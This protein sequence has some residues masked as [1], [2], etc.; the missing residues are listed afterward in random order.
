MNHE[1][2]REYRR[3]RETDPDLPFRQKPGAIPPE[4]LPGCLAILALI[5]ATMAGIVWVIC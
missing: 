2:H 1:Q 4:H 3:L 5:L